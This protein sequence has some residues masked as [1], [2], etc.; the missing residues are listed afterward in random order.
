MGRRKRKQEKQ[1]AIIQEIRPAGYI[2]VSTE[3]QADSGLGV[4]AQE[5]KILA[6][7]LVKGW[8][9]PIFYRDEG[10]SGTIVPEQRKGFSSLRKDIEAGKINAIITVDLSRLGRMASIII[11]LLD[12]FNKEN[13]GYVS[14][15]E[16]FDTSTPQGKATL[17]LFA[18]IAELERNQIAQRTKEALAEKSRRDGEAGGRLPYGYMRIFDMVNTKDGPVRKS[19]GVEVNKEASEIVRLI[20]KLRKEGKS[21]QAIAKTVESVHLP[22]PQGGYWYA[23]TIQDILD[24][25]DA[26]RGGKR[27]ASE[28]H[29]PIILD[30]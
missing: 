18:V 8:T 17:Q 23:S 27:G 16:N 12:S 28:I 26:Y 2:R 30:N 11:L 7:T 1:A 15:K 20:F 3:E 25:E 19:I 29:W 24:N 5:T 13:I 22:G 10:V 4:E 21:L 6:Q 9:E 14:C